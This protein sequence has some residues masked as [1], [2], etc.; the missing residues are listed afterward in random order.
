MF[1][2]LLNHGARLDIKN[3]QNYTPLALAAKL[4]RVEVIEIYHHFSYI[5][6]INVF[7]SN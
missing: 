3:R 4:A 1:E 7:L 2:Y 6:I 5:I